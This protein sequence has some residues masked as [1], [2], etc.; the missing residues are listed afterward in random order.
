MV[1]KI[2]PKKYGEG[3]FLFYIPEFPCCPEMRTLINDSMETL[4]NND[5]YA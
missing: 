3:R 1:L 4:N 5:K 2:A